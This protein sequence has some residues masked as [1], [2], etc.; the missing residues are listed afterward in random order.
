MTIEKEGLKFALPLCAAGI[1]GLFLVWPLGVFLLL[2]AAAVTLFFRETIAE[3]SFSA[4][5]IVSPASGRVIDI[6]ETEEKEFLQGPVRRVSIF[7]SVFDEHV[8]Y[9]PIAGVVDHLRHRPGNFHR[10]FLEEAGEANESMDIG[11]R[12]EK[13]SALMRQIAGII[14]RRIVCRARPGERMAGGQKLGLIRFGSRVDLF[15]PRS[16][17]LRVRAGDRVRGGRT[18][19]GEIR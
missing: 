12:G 11:L 14:A 8:N 1:V 6:R 15:L 16:A 4:D 13:A 19:L 10:A 2:L 17:V 9:A 18:I 7:M 3:A 5:Q